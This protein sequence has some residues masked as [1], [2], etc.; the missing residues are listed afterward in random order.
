MP[1]LYIMSGLP[2][3]GKT[4]LAKQIATKL[5]AT[6]VGFDQMWVEHENELPADKVDGWRFVRELAKSK[7]TENLQA[8]VS[9]V[10][11]DIN[12]GADHRDELRELAHKEGA[13][14]LVIFADTPQE[15]R[16]ER[17]RENLATQERHDVEVEN[18]KKTDAQF[19]IPES[20]SGV[21]SYRSDEDLV[22][23]LGKL[24]KF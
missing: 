23:W 3:S 11:D 21:V 22:G 6:Y 13:E 15:I 1:K 2:F 7:I 8:G 4:S 9:V 19:Q 16:L 14:P 17:M 10:F 12:I 20:E 5:D 24:S 18:L